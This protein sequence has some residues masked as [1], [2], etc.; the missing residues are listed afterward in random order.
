M[1]VLLKSIPSGLRMIGR[2][3]LKSCLTAV[4]VA[5]ERGGFAKLARGGRDSPKREGKSGG[6]FLKCPPLVNS[7]L[8]ELDS[9]SVTTTDLGLSH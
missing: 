8:P 7:N 1:F 9:L 2:G 6:H 3:F 5:L 4:R